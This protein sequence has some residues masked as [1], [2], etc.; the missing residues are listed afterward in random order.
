M[1]PFTFPRAVAAAF[2]LATGVAAG[3]CTKEPEGAIRVAVIGSNLTMADP[4]AGPLS[5]PQ[6]VLLA[7][8]AQGLVRFDARG[9]IEPGLAERWNVSDDGLSYIFRTAS[10]QWSDGR[11]VT[12]QQIARLLKRQF[13]KSSRNPLKDPFGAIEDVVAMTDRVIEIRL[14]APRP[15]LLQLLAQPELAVVRDG[16][17]TGPFKVAKREGQQLRFERSVAIPDAEEE[18]REDVRL[19]ATAATATL[20][21]FLDGKLDLVLGGTFADLPSASGAA[22]PRNALRFD[23]VAG[24][25][26]LIP[27][28]KDGPLADPE[29]RSLLG[30]AIDRDL[31]IASLGVPGLV[32]RAT[33]LEAGL[34]GGLDP[35]A[36]P[37]MATPL[38]DR[39]P[40][41]AAEAKRLMGDAPPLIRVAL[42]EGPG[43]RILLQRLQADWGALGIRVEA[44]GKGVPADLRLI[45]EV[46]P[47]TSAAWFVRHFRCG[48]AALCDPE[49]DA[50]MDSARTS[51]IPA[52]RWALLAEAARMIDD[53]ELFLPLTA[54][55]RWSLVSDRVVGF[56]GN[57]F[58]RHTL[59]ALEQKLDRERAE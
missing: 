5:P 21:A 55:V 7:N 37:W 22:L 13:A 8:V 54:P 23:P 46:A 41:L 28:R 24:M 39:Q 33:V 19:S 12:G 34:E 38:K 17:G 59:T 49:I 58:A 40:A 26:G 15:N 31:L 43:A 4:A 35:V 29:L 42:P 30:Q 1:R 47:S 9:E 20:R 14:T 27:V 56:A 10:A 48:T 6:Q 51:Q 3:S 11:K 18:R 44:A 52:Q 16:Q 50:L 57:R 25:F 32:P 53:A 45:D 36:P 2:L